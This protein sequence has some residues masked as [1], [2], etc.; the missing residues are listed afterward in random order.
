MTWSRREIFAMPAAVAMTSQAAPNELLTFIGTYTRG[1]SKGIYTMRFDTTKGFLTPPQLAVETQNP[2]FLALH[3]NGQFL[4]ACGEAGEGT[5]K[6]FAIDRGAVILKPL[7]SRPS[8]GSSPCHLV[9]DATGRNLLAVNYGPGST[10]VYRLNPDGSIGEESAFVQHS[11]SSVNERRQQGPHAHSVNLSKNNRFAVVADLGTDEYIVYAFDA[12][13]GSITRQSAAKVKGGSGPR[14]F[15]FH[16]NYR[17]AYGLNEMGS[18]VT[19]FRWSEEKGQLDEMATTTT[20]PAG[21]AGENNCA[22]ILVHPSG[23]FVYAS[24][25]GHN[26]IA[27]FECDSKTGAVKLIDHTPTQGEIPRNFR[28]TPDGKW[29]LAANQNSASVVVFALNP[30][31]GKLT[32]NGQTARVAFPV[33]IKFL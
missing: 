3:P 1:D 21:F 15:S 6:A 4:Y 27:V 32:P 30:A 10:I 19:V 14:H 7:N 28:L 25:R 18:S 8:K 20:L 29:L 33:C 2:S 13:R 11:G 9:V 16:P 31:T 12:A 17:F 22:E 24:N 5:V 26:S 23:K